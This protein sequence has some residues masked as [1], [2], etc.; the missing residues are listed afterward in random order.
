MQLFKIIQT[1]KTRLAKNST[2]QTAVM[3][4]SQLGI[5]LVR[6]HLVI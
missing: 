4:K 6:T 2:T 3:G 1:N 5:K